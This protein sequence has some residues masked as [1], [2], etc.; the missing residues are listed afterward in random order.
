MMTKKISGAHGRMGAMARCVAG[1]R[2]GA[3]IP[4]PSKPGTGRMFRIDGQ[5]LQQREIADGLVQA[6][7]R[8]LVA[9]EL[10]RHGLGH[11]YQHDPQQEV[12]HRAGERHQTGPARERSR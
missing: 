8:E 4:N 6:V 2:Y 10:Q 12:G 11:Q 1:D 9:G 5:K 7:G 3:M